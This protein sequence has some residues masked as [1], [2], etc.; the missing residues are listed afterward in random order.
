MI[1]A[2]QYSSQKFPKPP[3][4]VK[5]W[6]VAYYI[7]LPKVAWLK[8]YLKNQWHRKKIFHWAF[9]IFLVFIMV[10]WTIGFLLYTNSVI[11]DYLFAVANC[12]QGVIIFIDRCAMNKSIRNATVES[13]GRFINYMVCIERFKKILIHYFSQFKN[14]F[15]FRRWVNCVNALNWTLNQWNRQNIINIPY[16]YLPATNLYNMDDRKTVNDILRVICY[17]LVSCSNPIVIQ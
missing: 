16:H 3:N 2:A 13:L 17:S 9:R 7:R 1:I 15:N 12:L 10:T 14:L 4:P 6:K 8:F 11:F 5:P